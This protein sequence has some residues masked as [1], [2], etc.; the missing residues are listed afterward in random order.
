[1][2]LRDQ[3]ENLLAVADFAMGR[4]TKAEQ[5]GKHNIFSSALIDASVI[6]QYLAEYL[7]EPDYLYNPQMIGQ[8]IELREPT[9]PFPEKTKK[10]LQEFLKEHPHYYQTFSII[11]AVLQEYFNDLR[12]VSALGFNEISSEAQGLEGE[13]VHS[14]QG[15]LLPQMLLGLT[16]E[17]IQMPDAKAFE[18]GLGHA[19]DRQA[20]GMHGIGC[21][22]GVKVAGI[23]AT[24]PVRIANDTVIIHPQ[25][26]RGA[27][28]AFIY[29]E[30]SK[31]IKIEADPRPT[32]SLQNL[33]SAAPRR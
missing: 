7:S 11:S 20:F 2:H 28:P 8:R 25:K 23:F 13:A 5:T 17:M 22:F 1:M 19:F 12:Q 30:L 24:R 29:R 3:E 26:Q 31:G 6:G 10:R 15:E 9:Q 27:L 4:K 14:L 33:P 21:P 18:K 32:S 16:K